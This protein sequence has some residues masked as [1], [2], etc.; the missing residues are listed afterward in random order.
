[1]KLIDKDKVIEEINQILHDTQCMSCEYSFDIYRNELIKQIEAMQEVKTKELIDR[2]NKEIEYISEI[3]KE[4]QNGEQKE[5]YKELVT[6]KIERK[7]AF[8]KT[9]QIVLDILGGE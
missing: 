5:E 1:M 3:I 7:E 9:K 6:F 8:R 2:L 4:L